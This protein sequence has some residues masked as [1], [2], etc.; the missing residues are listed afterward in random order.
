MKRLESEVIRVRCACGW[1][2]S[3]PEDEVV[4][5]VQEHGRRVHN[6]ASTREEVLAMAM[7]D[8]KPDGDELE[9]LEVVDQPDA[10]RYEAR[11]GEQVIAIAEYRKA[12][13]RVIFLHTEVDPTFEGRGVGSRLAAG[14][15]DDVRARG[16]RM[17]VHCPFI[18]SYLRRHPEYRD[19][20]AS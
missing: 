13:D 11:L 4:S 3:G 2:T 17:T 8:R 19:L 10:R 5:S 1:E 9:S 15:L 12:R 7:D 14:A 16:L 6:M 18:A 20:L